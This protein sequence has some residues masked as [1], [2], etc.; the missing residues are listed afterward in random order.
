[1]PKVRFALLFDTT[2]D[3]R[4]YAGMTR[5]L[6]PGEHDK[7]G[8][9][10]CIDAEIEI[11]ETASSSVELTRKVWERNN[12]L[13]FAYLDNKG[14]GENRGLVIRGGYCELLKREGFS[15][16]VNS[17]LEVRISLGNHSKNRHHNL[18][19]P[20]RYHFSVYTLRQFFPIKW[21]ELNVPETHYIQEEINYS[22][23]WL[24]GEFDNWSDPRDWNKDRTSLDAK[25]FHELRTT[26]LSS[27][28][29]C[30][31]KYNISEEENPE[32]VRDLITQVERKENIISLSPR[33][34]PFTGAEF[35]YANMLLRDSMN[36]GCKGA[37]PILGY[38]DIY[39]ALNKIE[40]LECPSLEHEHK[41]S[42]LKGGEFIFGPVLAAMERFSKF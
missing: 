16:F 39:I 31:Q 29:H 1:M 2:C 42:P 10:D 25:T 7:Y 3:E 19:T 40:Q 18:T 21:E 28:A 30:V 33:I 37:I 32:K 38:S 12:S 14:H 13:P 4:R 20:D 34:A 17:E 22:L 6:S 27:S 23:R 35:Q 11:D 5:V 24:N 36:R 9:C 8:Y 15:D 26:Y 41:K